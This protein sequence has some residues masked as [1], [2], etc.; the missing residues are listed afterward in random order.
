MATQQLTQEEMDA[1]L[2]KHEEVLATEA[3]KATYGDVIKSGG[4]R[5][6]AGPAQAFLGTAEVAGLVDKGSTAKFTQSVLEAEKMGDM[7][8]AQTLVRD[9]LAQSIPITAE[10][11]ATRG[12]SLLQSLKPSAAIGGAGGFMTFVEDPQQSAALSSARLF[13][14]TLGATMAPLVMGSMLGLGNLASSIRGGRGSI[15]VASPDIRPS[16]AV[17]ETGAELIEAAG[18]RGISI[19]PGVATGDAALVADELKR[20]TVIRPQFAR[21]LGDKV[22]SNATSLEGLI[23]DLV[24]TILPEGKEQITKAIDDAYIRVDTKEKIPQEF[25]PLYDTLRNED[26]VQQAIANIKK[27]TGLS[28]EFNSLHPLSVGRINMIVKNLEA[29]IQGAPSDAAQKMI[30]AKRRLQEFGDKVSP[31]YK[32]ARAMTQRKKSAITVE[33]AMQKGGEGVDS[34]VPYQ[35]RVQ[36]FVNAFENLEAKKALD[37]AIENLPEG[38]AQKEARAKFNMLIELIPRVAEMDKLIKAKLG[39]DPEDLARRAGVTP[40]ATYSFLNFLNINNDRKFIEFILD[41]NKSVARLRE[42]MPTRTTK[43]QE[44]LRTFGVWFKENFDE[45]DQTMTTPQLMS[46]EEEDSITKASTSSKSKTYQR[47][48][49]SGKLEELREKN[50]RVYQQLLDSTRQTAIV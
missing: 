1:L 7:D 20:G 27:T 10:I 34:I 22:G 33:Q 13:N 17:R 4:I 9:T 39:D 46:R 8:L 11:Y 16:E 25:L 40:A 32:E 31:S 35:F 6:L 44:F 5:I 43:P 26:V 41:P 14:T 30:A 21:F 15:D 28:S 24:N 18:Q 49:Q 12:K 42:V 36:S 19:S 37:T 29:M 47:L 45:Y 23:D 3:A 2:D 48:L 50:P 38:P